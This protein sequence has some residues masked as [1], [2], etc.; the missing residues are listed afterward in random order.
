MN[1]MIYFLMYFVLV[2]TI[3]FLSCAKF[4]RLSKTGIT[5]SPCPQATILLFSWIRNNKAVYLVNCLFC[6]SDCR[7]DRKSSKGDRSR[8][9]PQGKT[10]WNAGG[11]PGLLRWVAIGT[12]EQ[13][14]FG[15]VNCRDKSQVACGR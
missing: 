12:A 9:E 5:Q 7:H 3:C 14:G 11:F 10:A 15:V 13:R 1:I 6:G 8:Q 2:S 4:Y